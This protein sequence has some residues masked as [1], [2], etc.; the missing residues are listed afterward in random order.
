MS[1]STVAARGTCRAARGDWR[2]IG[3]VGLRRSEAETKG[4]DD[5]MLQTQRGDEE[6]KD[7]KIRIGDTR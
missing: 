3:A 2:T 4:G 1:T 7:W 5:D 6:A